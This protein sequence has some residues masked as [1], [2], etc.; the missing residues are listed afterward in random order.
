MKQINLTLIGILCLFTCCTKYLDDVPDNSLTV[1][2]TIKDFQQLMENERFFINATSSGEFG[3]DDIYQPPTQLA[4]QPL[5]FRNGYIW[6]PD[7]DEGQP[8]VNW[9]YPFTKIYFANVAL[10]GLEKMDRSDVA[11]A[12]FNALKGWALFCRA[13]A[14]FD[15]QQVFGKPYRPAT[16]SQDLGLPLKLKPVLEEKV[17]RATVAETYKQI[18]T[19]L[20]QAAVL[21]PAQVDKVN[22]N[23]PTRAAAYALL[24]RSYLMMQEYAQ[25]LKSAS[26]S[27]DQYDVLLDYNAVSQTAL[28]P[29]SP[30]VDEVIYNALQWNYFNRYWEVDKQFYDSYDNNDLRKVLFFKIDP[31]S[32][33]FVY[34]GFYTNNYVAFTGLATDEVYLTKAE[35]QARLGQEEEALKTLNTLLIKRYKKDFYVPYTTANTIDILRLI[36]NERRKECVFRNLRWADLKRLNQDERYAKTLHRTV[37]GISYQLLPNDLRYTLLI[38]ANEIKATGV[39]QN[40]R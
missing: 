15:L 38:P 33:G 37:N 8:S 1:P 18:I 40:E 31:I 2:R 32:K 17:P 9:D 6:A 24:A 19:D 3:T 35:C 20:E 16:A 10:E 26:N 22:R 11:Q 27:L 21:L 23:R 34:K 28:L 13:H 39:Q 29:F 12:D 4:T 30:L 5:D 7:I 36:L 25:A 14:F